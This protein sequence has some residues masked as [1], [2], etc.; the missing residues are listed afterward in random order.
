MEFTDKLFQVMQSLLGQFPSLLMF[1]AGLVFAIIRWKKYPRISLAVAIA[2]LLLSVHAI[3]F[4]LA[5]VFLPD[6]LI[7]PREFSSRR[8]IFLVLSFLYNLG[9]AVCLGVLV[10]A[11]FMQRGNEASQDGQVT[12]S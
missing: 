6:L 11:I 5:Y 12:P 7:D 8:T 4:A 1:V 3:V 2:M 10:A 9:L